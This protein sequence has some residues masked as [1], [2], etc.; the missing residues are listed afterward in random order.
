MNLFFY[1]VLMPELASGRMAELV[2]LLDPGQLATVAGTLFAIADPEGHHPAMVAGP[3]TVHGR[4]HRAGPRFGAAELAEMDAYEGKDYAR[5][6]VE[7]R[8]ADGTLLAGEAYVW[9][10][11]TARLSPIPHGDFARYLSE[12]GAPALPG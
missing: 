8:L 2:A 11:P 5:R 12:S 7:A 4:L 10:G 3:D 1:G 9:L 6:A